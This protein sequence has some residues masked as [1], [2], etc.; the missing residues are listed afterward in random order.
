MEEALT[1]KQVDLEKANVKAGNLE[2]LLEVNERADRDGH[3]GEQDAMLKKLTRKATALETNGLVLRRRCA[4][5]EEMMKTETERRVAASRE[6]L[7]LEAELKARLLYLEE[8][9]QGA[10]ERLERLNVALDASRPKHE[11]DRVARDLD[12]LREDHL[13]LMGREVSARESQRRRRNGRRRRR[14][15]MGFL[16]DGSLF[17]CWLVG[18]D[19][20]T[21]CLR[22]IVA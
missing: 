6:A 5:V 3:S 2:G 18:F 19:R 21:D 16:W 7:E 20:W 15:R 10:T 9:K 1:E 12:S 22:C 17:V 13:A 4:S 14:R 11:Y 8:W